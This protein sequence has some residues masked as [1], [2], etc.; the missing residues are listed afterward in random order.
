MKR[1][2]KK[3]EKESVKGLNLQSIIE[4]DIN[5]EGIMRILYD[6]SNERLLF[7]NKT[8]EVIISQKGTHSDE[9][10]LKLEEKVLSK[11]DG[12]IYDRQLKVVDSE[13]LIMPKIWE[14]YIIENPDTIKK[15]L[16]NSLEDDIDIDIDS[17]LKDDEP[18]EL[19]INVVYYVSKLNQMKKFFEEY[20]SKAQSISNL[21]VLANKGRLKSFYKTALKKI[22]EAASWISVIKNKEQLKD[23]NV[24]NLST[25]YPIEDKNNTAFIAKNKESGMYY[26]VDSNESINEFQSFSLAENYLLGNNSQPIEDREI[27]QEGLDDGEPSSSEVWKSY[28]FQLQQSNFQENLED[29]SYRDEKNIDDDFE[30]SEKSFVEYMIQNPPKEFSDI[31]EATKNELVVVNGEEKVSVDLVYL[32]TEDERDAMVVFLDKLKDEQ[33]ISNWSILT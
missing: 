29:K 12:Q 25:Y 11:Y 24:V 4:Y 20:S 7:V 8:D 14:D 15:T 26:A 1:L 16:L 18:I 28:Q 19:K 30:Y 21:E 27:T 22:I 32:L 10:I 9:N 5:G 2:M 3:S 17:L 13:E 23:S 33:T 6:L 31:E